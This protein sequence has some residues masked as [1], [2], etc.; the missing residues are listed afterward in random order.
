MRALVPG[1]TDRNCV[2]DAVSL[3]GSP[4]RTTAEGGALRI[5]L[6]QSVGAGCCP[7]GT[8]WSHTR[9]RPAG[10]IADA[11]T[12]TGA[13]FSSL[14]F[15]C[16]RAGSALRERTETAKPK[17]RTDRVANEPPKCPPGRRVSWRRTTNLGRPPQ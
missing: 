5:A 9:H 13:G 7:A 8:S 16:A 1:T 12:P 14:L 15:S 17:T 3:F 11:G 4:K 2:G 6:A 10:G